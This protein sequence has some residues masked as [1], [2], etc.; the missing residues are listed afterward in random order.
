MKSLIVDCLLA[1]AIGLLLLLL[2]TDHEETADLD[3]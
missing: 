1:L 3:L 2:E